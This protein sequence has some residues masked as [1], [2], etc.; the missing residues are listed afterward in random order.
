MPGTRTAPVAG[1][2]TVTEN[3]ISFGVIDA[4]GDIYNEPIKQAGG[5]L[6]D[7]ADIEAFAVDY[8]ASTNASLFRI[9]QQVIWE[10]AMDADNA[11]VAYRANSESGINLLFRNVVASPALTFTGRLVAPIA[12]V[13]QGNQDIP[14]LVSPLTLLVTEYINMMPNFTLESM[15]YTGRRERKNNPRIP[16]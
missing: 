9:V 10:G 5:A 16:T 13:M 8:Q 1:A 4:S 3:L 2:L 11:V 15:Q 7:M 14:L 12:T 6:T